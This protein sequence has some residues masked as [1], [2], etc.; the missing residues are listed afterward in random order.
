MNKNE[1]IRYICDNSNLNVE[2]AATAIDGLVFAIEDALSH[3]DDVNIDELGKLTRKKNK[4][5]FAASK[6]LLQDVA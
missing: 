4:I 6:K 3:G 5:C 2:D 1:I